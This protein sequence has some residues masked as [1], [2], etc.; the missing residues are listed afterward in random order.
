MQD[1]IKPFHISNGQKV[2]ELDNYLTFFFVVIANR[3]SRGASAHY[4]KEYGIGVVEWRC[5]VSLA[6]EQSTTA[7]QISKTSSMNKSLVSRSLSK[8]E[9]LECVE[10]CDSS[11]KKKPRLL[12]LTS[13]GV[14]LYEKMVEDTLS[15]ETELRKGLGENEISELL[16][17]LRTLARNA[18]DLDQT[19]PDSL[20]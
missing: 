7:A 5:L 20:N 10:D 13:K 6:M 4:R 1:A 3:L 16:R 2:L 19:N 12:K 11:L 9:A 14:A 15:R 17:M 8:L 18:R